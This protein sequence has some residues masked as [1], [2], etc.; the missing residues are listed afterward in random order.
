[1]KKELIGRL[2]IMALKITVGLIFIG[3]GLEKFEGIE[4]FGD[5]QSPFLDFYRA[6][7]STGYML[8]FLGIAE[9]VG[10]VL[11]ATIRFSLVGVIWTIPL[12]LNVFLAHLNLIQSPKGIAYTLTINLLLIFFLWLDRKKLKPLFAAKAV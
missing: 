6:M 3:E 2:V 1:M 7:F 8:P 11:I 4:R 10:G 9:I 5:R 12:A